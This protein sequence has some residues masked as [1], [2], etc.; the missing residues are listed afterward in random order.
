MAQSQSKF[1]TNPNP[2]NQQ[3][4]QSKFMTPVQNHQTVQYSLPK[5]T[6]QQIPV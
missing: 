2:Q 6:A 5:N 1:S 4:P 3:A